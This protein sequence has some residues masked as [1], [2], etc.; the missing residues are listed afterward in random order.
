MIST[1]DKI[2][3]GQRRVRKAK[4][5]FKV[6]MEGQACKVLGVM[7]SQKDKLYKSP[8]T[9]KSHKL[10]KEEKENQCCWHRM[11]SGAKVL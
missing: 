9:K 1:R 10:V 2:S 4:T 7:L 3:M 11:S 5:N 6:A 8:N